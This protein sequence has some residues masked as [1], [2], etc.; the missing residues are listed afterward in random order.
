MTMPIAITPFGPDRAREIWE[1]KGLEGK[2]WLTEGE[3][4]FLRAL[5]STRG[6]SSSIT[7]VLLQVMRGELSEANMP[8]CAE[9]ARHEPECAVCCAHAHGGAEYP[10]R[11]RPAEPLTRDQM[12]GPPS[13]DEC[14]QHVVTRFGERADGSIGWEAVLYYASRHSC[15]VADATRYV[16]DDQTDECT[17]LEF[18]DAN[19]DAPVGLSMVN[20]ILALRVGEHVA[21]GGGAAAEFTVKRV[22]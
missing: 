2:L 12:L 20:A 13:G 14:T 3:R 5:W 19:A 17:L 7:S 10:G 11:P 9:H 6:G 4:W 8:S 16:V 15:H 22:R 1:G 18:L 21:G